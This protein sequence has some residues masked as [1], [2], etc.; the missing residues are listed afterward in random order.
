[1]LDTDSAPLS[2]LPPSLPPPV[3]PVD[4]PHLLDASM[5]W[6]AAGGVRRVLTAKHQGLQRLGWQ[7]QVMAPG[8][9]G[10]GQVD[11]GGVALP[12]TGGYR[13]VLRKGHASRLIERERPD[14][15]EAA[16]P[17]TLAWAVLA[18][19]TRLGVPA[20]AFC[21]SNLPALAERLFSER[22][23]ERARDYLVRLYGH[24][25]LVLAPSRGLTR[26]LQSW[27][28]RHAAYQPL[29]VDCE[30][31]NPEAAE[32]AWRHGLYKRLELAP[33]TRLVVYTGRFAPEK[34]LQLIADAV[35]RL[36][37]GHALLAVGA[38]PCPP[39]G[40]HV[41]LLPTEKDTRRLARLLASCD[42]YAH[43]GDQ[44]TFG[45]GVLEAM[46]CGTPVVTTTA[47]GLGELVDGVGTCVS[48]EDP[49]DWA[50]ALQ[51]SLGNLG[52]EPRRQAALALERAEQH[53]WHLILEQLTRRYLRLMGRTAQAPARIPGQPAA[54]TR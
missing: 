20:V 44:E 28:V 36:G 11:C 10:R 15:V 46:A 50:E 41:R 14:I 16:D 26:A 12:F 42:A 23:G 45:L 48:G 31:F 19:T 7:H 39:H 53:D 43:A 24:F 47:G 17:Y 8:A 30:V 21:H 29:G 51:A 49:G 5:F 3:S 18:A 25:D 54:L 1:M 9:T 4:G 35:E 52:G 13:F 38:G 2:S 37:P 27:G 34:N 6:G 22:M 33:R 32:P 40:R